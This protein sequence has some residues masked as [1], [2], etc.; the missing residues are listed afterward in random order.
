MLETLATWMTQYSSEIALIGLFSF[1]LLAASLLA[2]PWILA[3]LPSDYF[4]TTPTAS[5]R[6]VT[7]LLLSTVKTILGLLMILTGF[8]MMITPGPGLVCL[9]LGMALVEIPGKHLVLQKL[10]SRPSVFSTL[11]WLRKKADKTPFIL[12]PNSH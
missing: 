10:V 2:T 6:S 1:L 12:P 4:A 11:N 9:V 3:K 7:R 8:I 5:Q